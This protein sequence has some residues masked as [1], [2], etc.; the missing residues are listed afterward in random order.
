M[1]LLPLIFYVS[2]LHQSLRRLRPYKVRGRSVSLLPLPFPTPTQGLLLF[3]WLFLFFCLPAAVERSVKSLDS[4][5]TLMDYLI[6]WW[7]FAKPYPPEIEVVWGSEIFEWSERMDILF[8]FLGEVKKNKRYSKTACSLACINMM[9][10]GNNIVGVPFLKYSHSGGYSVYYVHIIRC[11]KN[12]LV[13][14]DSTLCPVWW[15]L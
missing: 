3:G 6:T 2:K 9:Q 8:F 14:W 1:F 15:L 5:C 11:D 7:K 10:Q 4:R 13:K 12:S